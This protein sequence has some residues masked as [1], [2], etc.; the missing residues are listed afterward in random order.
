[1]WWYYI[2]GDNGGIV[3]DIL[4]VDTITAGYILLAVKIVALKKVNSEPIL[5]VKITEWRKLLNILVKVLRPTHPGWSKRT[6][7]FPYWV[8][9]KLFI[10]KAP[11]I[12]APYGQII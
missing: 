3:S 5:T 2:L 8:Y 9:T 12:K 6:H 11:Y 10:C 7:I 4:R 1:M